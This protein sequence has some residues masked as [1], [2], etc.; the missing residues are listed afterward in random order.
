M[1]YGVASPTATEI[2]SRS[3]LWLSGYGGDNLTRLRI[4][5]RM[6]VHELNSAKPFCYKVMSTMVSSSN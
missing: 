5:V 4:V 2:P 1:A 3:F 6:E